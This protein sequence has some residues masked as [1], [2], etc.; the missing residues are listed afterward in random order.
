MNSLTKCLIVL[1][2]STI[3]LS[4]YAAHYT[5]VNDS[6][7]PSYYRLKAKRQLTIAIVTASVGYAT[8]GVGVM[9]MFV[10]KWDEALTWREKNYNGYIAV[11]VIGTVVGLSSIPIF[12]S[13]RKNRRKYKELMRAGVTMENISIP[14][15]GL[16]YKTMYPAFGIRIGF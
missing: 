10:T 6:I 5:P 1:L 7:P 13:A 9:G 2:I 8:L 15:P 11:M 3:S 12:I 14:T 16:S 4:S